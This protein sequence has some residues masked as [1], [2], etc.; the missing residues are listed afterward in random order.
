M[1][2]TIPHSSCCPF[3]HIASKFGDKGRFKLLEHIT[4][5]ILLN[6]KKCRNPTFG[7]VWRWHL[8]S[9]N[10]D[11]GVLRDSQNF[12]IQLQGSKHLSLK[13]SSCHWKTIEVKMSKVALHEPFGHL[14]HKLW[15]K[16]RSGIKLA[17]S[18]PTTKSRES[19][20]P[21][22][23][24]VEC[25]TPLESSQ[26]ELQFCFRPH[27]NRR[28]EQRVMNSQSPKSPNRDNFGTPP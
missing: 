19:T 14:Q 6:V 21:R 9:Q 5:F 8:H 4:Y 17:V 23:V 16:E 3:G 22:C 18:L 10:G 20:R 24:Q 28:F 1:C 7:R 2:H 12:R 25:N 11:L 26:G 13:R 27:P 15:Q